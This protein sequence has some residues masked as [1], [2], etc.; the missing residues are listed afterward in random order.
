MKIL[1]VES[2][3]RMRALIRRVVAGL[4][5]VIEECGDDDIAQ[6]A[7]AP[8]DW[9]L[10]SLAPQQALDSATAEV[11]KG[12]IIA[13]RI[14]WLVDYVDDEALEAGRRAGVYACVSKENLLTLRQ[15]LS[16]SSEPTDA[17][18]FRYQK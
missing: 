10:I 4:A 13:A 2:N 16:G 17:D 8:V 12:R 11:V 3:V 9:A 6:R 14:V 5:E 7:A 15:L 1:I 18:R